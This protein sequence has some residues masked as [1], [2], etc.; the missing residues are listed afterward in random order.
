[1][2]HCAS[3]LSAVH[4][5]RRLMENND[6]LPVIVLSG[7]KSFSPAFNRMPVGLLGELSVACLLSPDHGIWEITDTAVRHISRYYKNQDAMTNPERSELR[8]V[9]FSE[10][11]QFLSDF[12]H[13]NGNADA[14]IPYNLNA[15]LLKHLAQELG[16]QDRLDISQLSR[17]GHTWCSDVFYNLS[18]LKSHPSLK[19]VT[20]FSAGMGITLSAMN[21][22]RT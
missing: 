11:R 13:A 22:S 15:P 14:V 2:N 6:G 21:I 16:W 9:F 17:V 20:L 12:S 8:T 3:G 10:L 19:S 18:R 7:E 5:A 1:M 4:L